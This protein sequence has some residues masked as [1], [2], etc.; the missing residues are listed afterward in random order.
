[1]WAE[2]LRTC[3]TSD[4]TASHVNPLQ[5]PFALFISTRSDAW[6]SH[7]PLNLLKLVLQLWWEL[8]I[9]YWVFLQGPMA[10]V[11]W[12]LYSFACLDFVENIFVKA[13]N[14]KNMLTM[15]DAHERAH[16]CPP[17]TNLTLLAP[18]LFAYG[19]C[20]L[21]PPC[22]NNV[23][24]Y[25]WG[26]LVCLFLQLNENSLCWLRNSLCSQLYFFPI[27]FWFCF[28]SLIIHMKVLFFK[29]PVKI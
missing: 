26:H 18:F 14:A 8:G 2:H 15:R 24:F 22:L 21:H 27:L 12:A 4:L 10:V 25:Y 3:F 5:E 20:I 13:W 19:F 6:A 17:L 11:L 9:Q 7:L 28:F 23:F 16:V 1:M 29:N